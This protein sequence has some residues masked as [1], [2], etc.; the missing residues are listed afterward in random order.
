MGIR[1][2]TQEHMEQCE[3]FSHEQRNLDM[4]E[5]RGKLIF[6]RRMVP[7]LKTMN[8]HDKWLELKESLRKKKEEQLKNKLAKKTVIVTKAKPKPKKLGA[9]QKKMK[10]TVDSFAERR[11]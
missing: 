4:N 7:K 8:D 10:E 11:K 1:V 5:E 2:E 9:L 3:G 6:W